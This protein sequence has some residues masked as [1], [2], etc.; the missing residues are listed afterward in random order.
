MAAQRLQQNK[1]K[2]KRI[3]NRDVDE[4]Y[5]Q[6]KIE[7]LTAVAEFKAQKPIAVVPIKR[8]SDRVNVSMSL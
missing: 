2:R 7:L 1:R 5:K 4:K 6:V 8:D 3:N